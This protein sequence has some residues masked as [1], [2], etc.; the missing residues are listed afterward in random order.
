MIWAVQSQ[1][2][3]EQEAVQ[4]DSHLFASI[5]LKKPFVPPLPFSKP[6]PLGQLQKKNYEEENHGLTPKGYCH[7]TSIFQKQ[8]L[9]LR[10]MI[11]EFRF[12]IR[13]VLIGYISLK[14]PQA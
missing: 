12:Q 14:W 1:G 9:L 11:L 2:Q 3:H 8:S 6:I 7:S 4:V 10:L 5:S 13:V